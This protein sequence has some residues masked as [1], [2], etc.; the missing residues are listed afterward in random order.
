[1]RVRA[2][3]DAATTPLPRT[4]APSCTRCIARHLPPFEQKYV[5]NYK[6]T[7]LFVSLAEG[8]LLERLTDIFAPAGEE[9]GMTLGV[10]HEDNFARGRLNDDHARPE[11]EIGCME[12]AI[13]DR[14]R[15]LV[16]VEP[17]SVGGGHPNRTVVTT[18]GGSGIG[19]GR[20]RF[21]LGAKH[22]E[23]VSCTRSQV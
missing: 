23:W 5:Y 16:R 8:T 2:F 20:C 10:I 14:P 7:H 1:V 11:E 21:A 17:R 12:T 4:L 13:R 15:R 3:C 9:P 6:K 18:S 19:G 22:I